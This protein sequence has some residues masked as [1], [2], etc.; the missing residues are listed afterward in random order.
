MS[1]RTV[2]PA[3]RAQK[4]EKDKGVKTGQLSVVCGLRSALLL[5]TLDVLSQKFPG[6]IQE[7]LIK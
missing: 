4:I 2:S 1:Y 5:D 7:S 3:L 6:Q